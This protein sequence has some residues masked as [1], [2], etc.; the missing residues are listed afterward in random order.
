MNS[1]SVQKHF[2]TRTRKSVLC[3]PPRCRKYFPPFPVLLSFLP[4]LY[5]QTEYLG[6]A[7][8]SHPHTLLN[9]VRLG[10]PPR[11]DSR[12]PEDGPVTSCIRCLS[13]QLY[14]PPLAI[15]QSKT[16]L[17]HRTVGL[18]RFTLTLNSGSFSLGPR[19]FTSTP[20]T[21]P[22]YAWKG[23]VPPPYGCSTFEILVIIARF[24]PL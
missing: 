16:P 23:A 8:C 19:F 17:A 1:Y 21:P 24:S 4:C 20:P 18:F 5:F 9:V 10:N 11:V 7:L 15:F 6:Q 22:S 2:G 12:F 3:R 14:Q 13:F